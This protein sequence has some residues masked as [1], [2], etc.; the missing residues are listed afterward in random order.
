ML[1]STEPYLK[2]GDI[3]VIIPEYEQFYG[4]SANGG[5]ELLSMVFD[6]SLSNVRKL[7]WQ[8]IKQSHLFVPQYIKSKLKIRNYNKPSIAQDYRHTAFNE[9]GDASV[10]WNKEHKD[11]VSSK[12][13][14]TAVFNNE[15]FEG[16]LAFVYEM[17]ERGVTTFISFPGIEEDSYSGTS[18]SIG[19]I[20]KELANSPSIKL[21][22]APKDYIFST[23]DTYD[24]PYHLRYDAVVKRTNTLVHF[25]KEKLKQD[26]DRE[27]I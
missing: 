8:Q 26:K 20:Y 3:V 19:F 15:T 9:Y 25:L 4:T 10:H 14:S 7:D 2:S 6:V 11:Y 12:N 1:T 5:S 22:G 23:E 21:L 16:L 18:K 24:T 17:Q 27:V 13:D